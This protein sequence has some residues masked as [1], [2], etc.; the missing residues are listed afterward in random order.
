[1]RNFGC[2][3]DFLVLSKLNK[4]P[5]MMGLDRFSAV[6][7]QPLSLLRQIALGILLFAPEYQLSAADTSP[8]AEYGLKAAI[9]YKLTK[10]VEWPWS[11]SD[12]KPEFFTI[13]LLGDDDF[14]SALD[15]LEGRT[16]ADLSIRI[17]RFAQSDAID[18][19]CQMLFISASKQA[20]LSPILKGLHDKAILT[21][22][23]TE[24][25]AAMGGIV[26]FT[27]EQNRIGFKI[28]L[29]SARRSKL[30]IAS[31]LLDLATVIGATDEGKE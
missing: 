10:F 30:E 25:F 23:D 13:C 20:F 15:A 3:S 11:G 9:I 22:G 31:P 16:A 21:L 1:M 12:D 6:T 2:S 28:N 5:S 18:E 8:T 26:Q 29:K 14:G 17:N 4:F 7:I 19:R 24:N 27:R